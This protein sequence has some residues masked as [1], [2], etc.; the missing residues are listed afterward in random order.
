MVAATGRVESGS[1]IFIT[2]LTA[3][4]GTRT[5]S[6]PAPAHRTFSVCNAEKP[7]VAK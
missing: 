7:A 1:Q 3:L 5:H 2:R 6:T 4:L